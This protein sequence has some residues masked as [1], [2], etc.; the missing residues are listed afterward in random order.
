MI[1]LNIISFKSLMGRSP[2]RLNEWIAFFLKKTNQ[3]KNYF[4]TILKRML[5]GNSGT[6]HSTV[7]MILVIESLLEEN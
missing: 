4:I 7:I 5:T 1:V 3:Y 2:T 6:H